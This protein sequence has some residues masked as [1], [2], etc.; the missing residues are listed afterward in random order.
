MNPESKNTSQNYIY[1][2]SALKTIKPR[3][4]IVAIILVVL[5]CLV[6]RALVLS[7]FESATNAVYILRETAS[8]TWVETYR[9]DTIL[10]ARNTWG[11]N[12]EMNK[13]ERVDV[14][15][16][17]GHWSVGRWGEKLN[18]LTD[19]EGMRNNVLSDPE[20]PVPESPPGS[21]IGQFNGRKPF[22]MGN[23]AVFIAPADGVLYLGIND[24]DVRDNIGELELE[25]IFY[26]ME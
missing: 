3:N 17:G 16:I 9:Y 11:F 21:L 14:R 26:H 22:F 8:A 15:V 13:G 25:L 1:G 23:Q 12:I 20:L 7:L 2:P 4:A 18:L 10:F 19:G 24:V 5:L 6:G